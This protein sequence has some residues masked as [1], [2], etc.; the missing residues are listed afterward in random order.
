MKGKTRTHGNSKKSIYNIYYGM[1]RRCYNDKVKCYPHY[2][3]R[4]IKVCDRWLQSSQNFIEDM[5]ERPSLLHSLER[6]DVNGHYCPEN[7]K[8][9]TQKEQVKNRRK[10]VDLQN[11]ILALEINQKEDRT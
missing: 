10:I 1:K 4:G 8:W 11:K 2:G 3:G 5:G 7:C 9:A 6:V